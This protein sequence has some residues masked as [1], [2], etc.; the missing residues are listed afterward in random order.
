MSEV[1]I[2]VHFLGLSHQE[3]HQLAAESG[4]AGRIIATNGRWTCFVPFEENQVTEIA[5]AVPDIAL[6]WIYAADYALTLNFF[7][8]RHP[9]GEV[10]VV[11]HR[12]PSDPPAIPAS[13]RL[14]D[15]LAKHGVLSVEA[16]ERFAA[17]ARSEVTPADAREV[18]DKAA[19]LL[20]LPAYEWLSPRACLDTSVEAM[21]D[22]FSDAE[23]IVEDDS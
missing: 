11:W 21:R 12:E 13:E 4:V 14:L 22:R 10:S 19:A 17:L 20:G 18:R 6:L 15:A 1:S 3:T 9:L 16:A 8:A 23:D 7:L 2:S 5:L